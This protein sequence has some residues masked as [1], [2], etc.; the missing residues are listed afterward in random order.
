MEIDKVELRKIL[1]GQQ[2]Q[3]ERCLGSLKEDFDHKLDAVLEYVKDMPA[4]MDKQDVMFDKM[5]AMAEDITV[6]K[7]TVKDHEWR[8]QKIEA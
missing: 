5:G 2:E 4:I 3:T 8:L 7:E 6:I 1:G